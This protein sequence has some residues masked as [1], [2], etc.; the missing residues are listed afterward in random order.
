MLVSVAAV[1]AAD[2]RDPGLRDLATVVGRMPETTRAWVFGG[3]LLGF[4]VK[5]PLLG[6]H[7]WL[8]DTYNIAPPVCRAL[9]SAAMSKMGAF[10]LILI[11]APC[12]PEEMTRFAPQLRL[13]AVAGV[14]Y[15]ALLTLAQERLLDVLVYGS[16][17]HLSILAL[18]VFSSVGSGDTATTGLSGA[19]LLMLNHGLIMTMLF[20][21][22]ARVLEGGDS[23]DK[24]L[25]SGLRSR[26][27]RLAAFLLL[28]AFASA[29]LP[30]LGN[31]VGEI[32]VIFATFRISP[33]LA[34]CA[35]LGALIGA[36]ALIRT[37]HSIFLGTESS[38]GRHHARLC[39]DLDNGET[40]LALGMAGI[41]LALGL[42]PMI[43]LRPL[44]KALL[45][46]SPLGWMG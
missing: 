8:R 12:F 19:V 44:E 25:L 7:G 9:L 45:F 6:F 11:L 15:G 32:L 31:F 10:G 27:R 17:S 18:G 29:S 16:L 28:S 35:G 22:D 43:L 38:R 2:L 33:V 39:P 41:W 13:L 42:Y 4:A 24:G 40:A 23:P 37:F 21:L 1:C 5:L 36:A 3:F 14:I 34:F 30:G 20:A 46:L 26:H